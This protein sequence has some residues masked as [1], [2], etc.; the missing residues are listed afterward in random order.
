MLSPAV[1]KASMVVV[2]GTYSARIPPQ[3]RRINATARIFF[4]H[5]SL[6]H[7]SWNCNYCCNDPKTGI[8]ANGGIGTNA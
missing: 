6:N 1:I 8:A 2:Q 4:G 3:G 7:K 5:E